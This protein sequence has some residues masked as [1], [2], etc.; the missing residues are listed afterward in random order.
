MCI[1][2]LP[3]TLTPPTDNQM[4]TSFVR[5]AASQSTKPIVSQ[6]PT[7][8]AF[9]PTYTSSSSSTT[10]PSHALPAT[11]STTLP[12]IMSPATF[13]SMAEIDAPSISP[14]TP[15]T[16]SS[17]TSSRP[18]MMS[19]GGGGR[20]GI[21]TIGS[22]GGPPK[23]RSNISTATATVGP[24]GIVGISIPGS[25]S[26]VVTT[27]SL[28]SPTNVSG[29][30]SSSAM[31]TRFMN[32]PPSTL[33]TTTTT[34]A[35]HMDPTKLT[36]ASSGDILLPTRSSSSHTT[37]SGIDSNI[38]SSLSGSSSRNLDSSQMNDGT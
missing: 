37:Q 10:S 17:F 13:P 2:S 23:H 18:T 6:R 15:K 33:S 21:G 35:A 38:P 7:L 28:T 30:L 31:S 1:G 8:L 12:S 5:T 22:S 25:S 32:T 16:T 26:I 9:P 11:T 29:Q 4:S 27:P 3:T 36:T 14:I 34:T 19:R 20:G 24:Q